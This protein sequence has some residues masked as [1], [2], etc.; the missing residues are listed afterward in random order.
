MK[1]VLEPIWFNNF[2]DSICIVLAENESHEQ[3]AYICAVPDGKSESDQ[4]QATINAGSKLTFE[5]AKG[6]FPKLDEKIYKK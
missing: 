5:Q 6:F 3:M 2:F 1:Q 4:V